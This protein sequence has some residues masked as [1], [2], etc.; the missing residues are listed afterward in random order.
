MWR[1]MPMFKSAQ[2]VTGVS[3][4]GTQKPAQKRL[5]AT[6]F[7]LLRNWLKS[8]FTPLPDNRQ[9]HLLARLKT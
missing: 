2:R 5:I 4:L 7:Q 3:P 8:N 6:F 9:T 1:A